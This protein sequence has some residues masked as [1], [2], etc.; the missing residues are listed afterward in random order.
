MRAL[1]MIALS[2]ALI[3]SLFPSSKFGQ[4][5]S[6]LAELFM[7]SLRN[8]Y[9]GKHSKARSLPLVVDELI[10]MM[11]SGDTAQQ[12]IA[13]SAL[14]RPT[15]QSALNASKQAS[16]SSVAVL[17]RKLEKAKAAT[18]AAEAAVAAAEGGGDTGV[19]VWGSGSRAAAH[20]SRSRTSMM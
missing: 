10:Q 5:T 11:L 9:L 13:V 14:H 7:R 18:A 8:L 2:P 1:A 6:I 4:N 12:A 20:D 15:S 3:A 19:S 17:R 16:A